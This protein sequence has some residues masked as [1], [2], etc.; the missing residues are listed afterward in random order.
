[1]EKCQLDGCFKKSDGK[2][3]MIGVDRGNIKVRIDPKEALDSEQKIGA[4]NET[5]AFYIAEKMFKQQAA[6]ARAEKT[7]RF[8]HS[9]PETH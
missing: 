9:Y 8:R 2:N 3:Y 4:C 6:R 1:M 5:H 7:A